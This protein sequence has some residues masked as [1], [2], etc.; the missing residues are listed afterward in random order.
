LAADG[1]ATI[2]QHQGLKC[3]GNFDEGLVFHQ[4][5][6]GSSKTVGRFRCTSALSGVTCVVIATGKGFFISRQLVKS[7]G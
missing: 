4:L 7:V 3:T 5:S 6:Y 1:V 2:C